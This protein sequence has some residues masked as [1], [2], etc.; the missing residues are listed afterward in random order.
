[1]GELD[2]IVARA[3]AAL[4]AGQTALLATL[5][6]ARGSSYRRPGARLLIACDA[7]AAGA[8][9]G[10]CLERDLVRR[11]WWRTDGGA[12]AL[13][14]YDSTD[15]EDGFG[16]RVGLGCNGVVDVLVQRLDAGWESG[17]LGFIAGCL[18]GEQVGRLLTV[19]RSRDPSAAAR[20]LGGSEAAAPAAGRPARWRRTRPAQAAWFRCGTAPSRR[21]SRRSG[22]RRSC[23]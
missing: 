5:V 20:R 8:V 12:P 15:D 11:G 2:D 13:V 19:F 14:T 3:R 10:G 4:A 7:A 21:W 17:A 6:S 9:S 23:S 22:P 16:A 1:M 18:A